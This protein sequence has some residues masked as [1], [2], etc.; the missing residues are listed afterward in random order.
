MKK[1][2]KRFIPARIRRCLVAPCILPA[3]YR[4][5]LDRYEEMALGHFE[6]GPDVA[7]AQ[8]RLCAHVLDKG[9][10]RSDW[11]PGH[12][13]ALYEQGRCL[14]NRLAQ[15]P[16]GEPDELKWAR[17]IFEEYERR[18][19]G[20]VSPASTGAAPAP[21]AA[22]APEAVA[23]LIR[24]RSSVRHFQ[25]RPVSPRVL[26]DI[27]AAAIQAPSSCNRQT[28][29][30]YASLDPARVHDVL[31]CFS[32]FTGFSPYVPCA[33]VFCADLRPYYFPNEIFIPT[34]DTGLAI[35]NALLMATAHGLSATP[36]TWGSRRSGD[37]ER[38]RAL[39]DVPK[40]MDIVAGAAC[41]YPHQPAV[42]PVRK[43]VA[44]TL[45]LR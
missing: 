37:E 25:E 8:L 38:L 23:R 43:T 17:D 7:I 26:E 16:A 36:L 34:L 31:A 10:C 45:V 33:L 22:L 13:R 39:L 6:N 5:R 32:G 9:L 11:E 3:G 44:A 15:D 40:H 12:S 42:P 35:E 24:T 29:R 28:L 21:D 4:S 18:E 27:V 1:F 19:A 30:V 2:L 41:G 14:L 20:A